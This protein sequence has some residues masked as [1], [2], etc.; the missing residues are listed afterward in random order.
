M[1]KSAWPTGVELT[2]YL[3]GLGVSTIPAGIIAADEVLAAVEAFEEIAGFSP[4][5]QDAAAANFT[6]DPP[7]RDWLDLGTYF[8]T[9]VSVTRDGSTMTLATD[10]WTRPNTG[11]PF[12]SLA[13][14]GAW[15]GD[16]QTIVVNGKRGY[17]ATIPE[18]LWNAVRDYAAAKVYAAAVAAGTVNLGAKTEIKQKDVTLKFAGGS[19]AMGQDTASKLKADA[20]S[21]FY[22]FKR[23]S[24][25]G[26]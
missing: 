19:S 26:L 18:R 7:R 5:L 20:E 16:P 4:F 3:G 14:N 22:S 6:F 17:S 2:T 12:N 23:L 21:V 9:I 8:M 11:A 24:L 15:C 25:G 1:A 13:L 10:Y